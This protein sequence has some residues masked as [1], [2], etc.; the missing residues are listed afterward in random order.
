MKHFFR[1][2]RVQKALNVGDRVSKSTGMDPP[3]TLLNTFGPSAY[4]IFLY[5]TRFEDSQTAVDLPRTTTAET[6]A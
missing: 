4:A 1:I 6:T 2:F 3:R 5:E